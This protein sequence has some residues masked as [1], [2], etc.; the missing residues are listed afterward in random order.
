MNST[1]L[2]R[3]APSVL[4]FL[5]LVVGGLQAVV[6]EGPVTWVALAQLAVLTATSATTWLVPLAGPR[7]RGAA[8]VGL[9]ILGAVVTLALPFIAAGGITP[10][11]ALLVA[12]AV[13]KVVASQLGVAI[14]LD[15]TPPAAP[16]KV[17][18]VTPGKLTTIT[19]VGAA[20]HRAE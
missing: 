15:P 12:V 4:S 17:V 11:E 10:A 5:V 20:E 8:K 1:A 18:D 3:Y 19:D 9:E 13:I 6:A 16:I 14:R 2:Q 7:W